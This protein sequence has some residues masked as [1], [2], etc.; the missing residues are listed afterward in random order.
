MLSRN[1]VA[2][3][4]SIQREKCFRCAHY[5]N[6]N[7]CKEMWVLGEMRMDF[8]LDW[9]RKMQLD[10]YEPLPKKEEE[11]KPKRMLRIGDVE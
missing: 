5:S 10:H 4:Q 11:I 9:K 7:G 6:Q 2:E 1:E 8:C 3:E